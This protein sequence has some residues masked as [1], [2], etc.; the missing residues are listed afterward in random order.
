MLTVSSYPTR[1]SVVLRG[2]YLLENVLNAPPPPPPPDVP[3]LNEDAVGVARVAARSRW[4]S[5]APTRSAPPATR[6]MDPLG[7]GLENYDADRPVAH[8]GRQVPGRCQRRVP[9]R[10]DASPGRPK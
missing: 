6:K 3:A 7:F 10:Q 8:A 2:K 1:T 9:Q 5:T 4:S